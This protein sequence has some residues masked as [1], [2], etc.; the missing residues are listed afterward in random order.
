M[1]ICD[2]KIID[3]LLDSDILN[4]SAVND[5]QLP[6]NN[7]EAPITHNNH[8]E[9]NSFFFNHDDYQDHQGVFL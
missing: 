9:S 6:S 2:N 4:A 7:I 5:P 1:N 8:I 3:D